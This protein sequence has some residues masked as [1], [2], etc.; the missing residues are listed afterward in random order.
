MKFYRKYWHYYRGCHWFIHVVLCR[1]KQGSSQ[2]VLTAHWAA[3]RFTF[4]RSLDL[5]RSPSNPWLVAPSGAPEHSI[6]VVPPGAFQKPHH[7]F[8]SQSDHLQGLQGSYEPPPSL[9]PAPDASAWAALQ[10][11]PEV[12]GEVHIHHPEWRAYTHRQIYIIIYIYIQAHGCIYL[13]IHPS[14]HPSYLS[15]HP[16]IHPSIHLSYLS[17]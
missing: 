9:P 3:W 6:L 2:H 16:S 7:V 14:I 4:Q 13:C 8:F 17:I 12:H 1:F 11:R 5:S 15:I 10:T